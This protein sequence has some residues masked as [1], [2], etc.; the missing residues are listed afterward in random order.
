VFWVLRRDKS[1][2]NGNYEA[3]DGW[4]I[5]TFVY[6][7]VHIMCYVL[8]CIY[9]KMYV[10]TCECVTYTYIYTMHEYIHVCVCVCV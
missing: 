8:A 5:G 4:K 3:L 9:V 7:N 10:D 6:K 1:H 2:S